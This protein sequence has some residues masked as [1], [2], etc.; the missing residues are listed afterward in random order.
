MTEN[1]A[2]IGTW[3]LEAYNRYGNFTT[4]FAFKF[5]LSFLPGLIGVR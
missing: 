5:L 2:K 3:F 1:G 4:S